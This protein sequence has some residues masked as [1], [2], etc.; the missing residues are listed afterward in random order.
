METD[1]GTVAKR[2]KASSNS[3]SKKQKVNPFHQRL[4]RLTHYQAC[5]LLGAEGRKLIQTGMQHFEVETERHVYLGGDLYRVRIPISADNVVVVT[6]TMNSGR[7]KQ[8]QLNCDQCNKNC[9]HMGAALGHLLDAKST[10]GLAAP[11]DET[12][13]LE[14]LTESELLQRALAEREKRAN[15]E[16]MQVRA[17]DK[18]RP[19]SDYVITS[20][21]SGKTYRVA[22]RGQELGQSYCSCPD[23]RTNHLGTCKH[24]LHTLKKVQQRFSSS[25]LRVAYKRKNISVR[26]DYRQPIGLLFNMPDSVPDKMA[27]IVGESGKIPIDGSTMMNKIQALEQAG[28]D[29]HV[30]P[31]AEEFIQ[32][33]LMQKRLCRRCEEVRKSPSAH[34]LRKNLL[35]V[36]LLPYQLDGIAFAVGA[37]RAILADD[38]G[39]GK[40]IQGIGVAELLA[41]EVDIRRV[42]VVCPASLKSQWRSEVGKFSNRTCQLVMGSGQ[43][44]AA[45]YQSDAFFTVCNYEQVMR[46]L[47]AIESVSWDLIILDEGQRIKNWESKTS[48]VI[49]ALRSQFALVLSGTPLENRL[50]ELYTVVQFVDDCHL[51]PAYRFFHKHRVVDDRGRAVGYQR[52]DELRDALSPILLRRTRAEVAKQLPERTDEVIRIQ[53]TEEQLEISNNQLT[54]AARIAAKAFLTEMDLLR[55]QKALLLARMAAD[56]TFLIDKKEPEF[57]SKLE[58]LEELLTGLIEVPDRKIVLFSEWRTMLDRIEIKLDAIGCDYVRLDG[59]VPQKQRAAIVKKFQEDPNCRLILMTNAGSTGLNLQSANTVINVDLPWNPAVLEQRIARAHRMGQKNPVT[60]YKLVTEDT[61]EEKL[62]ET[63]ES[64]QDLAN[65]ALDFDSDINEITMKSG[66]TNIR[67]RLEKILLPPRPAAEDQSQKRTVEKQV[68]SIQ[69]RRERVSAASGQLLSAALQLVGELVVSKDSPRPSS[70]AVDKLSGSLAECV[71]RDANGRPQLT[72]TL[73]DNNALRGL[74]ETLAM[75]LAQK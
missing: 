55:L 64:K 66:I 43:E 67:E 72:I 5:Q 6:I 2:S 31:D 23:F 63:L 57:S 61:I 73:P 19:W 30:Y 47:T 13:P 17:T 40:T 24:I 51:G 39:L 28:F 1:V 12:V 46:D 74:A 33:A 45:L 18:D 59:Q 11:P 44:R 65:A 75:L 42:L 62:L 26:V 36:E 15:E 8:L 14:N 58:R 34:P 7:E 32:R 49:R 38:M 54:I 29:V 68:E 56:S 60:V 41:K 10:M 22:L 20:I 53:P 48:Q 9:E 52:L 21:G 3:E 50:D 71:Q 37:G 69:Q 27:E 25:K 35:S 70:E 4:A 16:K